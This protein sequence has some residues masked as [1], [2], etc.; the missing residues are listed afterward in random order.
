M[1]NRDEVD[2]GFEYYTKLPE[3]TSIQRIIK[4]QLVNG[5]EFKLGKGILKNNILDD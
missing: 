1:I 2:K 4:L 5:A 3:E